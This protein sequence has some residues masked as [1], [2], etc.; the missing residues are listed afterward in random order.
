MCGL[1]KMNRDV[2]LSDNKGDYKVI[3]DVDFS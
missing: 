2:S 1:S 3:Q